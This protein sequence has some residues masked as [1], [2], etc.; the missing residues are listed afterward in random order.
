[1]D[2]RMHIQTARTMHARDSI[3]TVILLS[4]RHNSCTSHHSTIKEQ[5]LVAD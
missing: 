4:Y 2:D 5:T 3:F 1:M